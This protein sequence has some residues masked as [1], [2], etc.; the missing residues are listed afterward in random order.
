MC[1]AIW[2]TIGKHFLPSA[3]CG[4]IFPARSCQGA[5]RSNSQ[6]VRSQVNMANE[7]KFCSQI[8]ST[9]EALVVWHVVGHCHGEE[10]GPFCWPVPAAGLQFLM[11]LIDF[12][13]ILPRCNG[14]TGVQKGIVDQT[15]SRPPNSDHDLFLV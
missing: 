9:F 4:S 3:G 14:F 11:H 15:S 7:A 10:L 8:H 2:G 13:S 5:W 6:L 1:F 12:L